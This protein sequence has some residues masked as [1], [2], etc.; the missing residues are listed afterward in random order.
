MKLPTVLLL[1]L[2][3]CAIA[4]APQESAAPAAAPASSHVMLM[5]SDTQWGDA[6]PRSN[7]ARR[8]R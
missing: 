1:S 4:A 5:A 6:H 8:R 3:P 7:A 2:L